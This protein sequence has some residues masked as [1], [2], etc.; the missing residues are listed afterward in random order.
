LRPNHIQRPADDCFGCLLQ[1]AGLEGI[2]VDFSTLKLALADQ[3]DPTILTGYDL[4]NL[5]V[6]AL[7]AISIH[8]D[9]NHLNSLLVS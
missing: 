7:P 6:T 1:G 8:N 9:T 3:V 4:D 5:D 2:E